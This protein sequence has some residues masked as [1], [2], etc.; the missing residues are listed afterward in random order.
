MKM[1]I[2]F[3]IENRQ[4]LISD[5]HHTRSPCPAR[6]RS[7]SERQKLKKICDKGAWLAEIQAT[8]GD[9]VLDPNASNGPGAG[10]D[11]LLSLRRSIGS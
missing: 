7:S 11:F 6:N 1:K 3:N 8:A 9:P 10:Q 4:F 2:I 5:F